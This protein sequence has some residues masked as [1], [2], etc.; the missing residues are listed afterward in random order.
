MLFRVALPEICACVKIE[1]VL[2]ILHTEKKGTPKTCC[3]PFDVPV[4]ETAGANSAGPGS[5]E[6][7]M[8]RIEATKRTQTPLLFSEVTRAGRPHGDSGG[9]SLEDMW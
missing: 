7:A 1:V 8:G 6:G 2:Y 5:E 3:Y 9:V 4:A